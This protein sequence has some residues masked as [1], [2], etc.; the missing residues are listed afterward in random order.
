M[1][2]MLRLRPFRPVT[3]LGSF[4]V[5]AAVIAVPSPRSPLFVWLV[6]SGRLG[7][8]LERA[9]CQLCRHLE[10]NRCSTV[11]PVSSSDRVKSGRIACSSSSRSTRANQRMELRMALLVDLVD[12][13]GLVGEA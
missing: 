1:V 12:L 2:F 4:L 11:R 10:S 3:A 9:C 6:A 8:C 13:V 5:A 7:Q